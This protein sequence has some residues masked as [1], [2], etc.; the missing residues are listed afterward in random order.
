MFIPK[1][2]PIGIVQKPLCGL[3]L[4]FGGGGSAS[5]PCEAAWVGVPCHQGLKTPP[6]KV[7]VSPSSLKTMR[8]VYRRLKSN[9]VVEPLLFDEDELDAQAFLAMMA[10]D[11]SES[12]PLYVEIILVCYSLIMFYKVL[13]SYS[14]SFVTL[15]RIIRIGNSGKSSTAV[16][17]LLTPRNV[18]AWSNEWLY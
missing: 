13:I 6:V 11:P 8:A 17:G 7:F 9:V 15:A 4:H 12:T 3:V 10:V 2:R 14:L 5:Q 18:E 1:Y 16:N